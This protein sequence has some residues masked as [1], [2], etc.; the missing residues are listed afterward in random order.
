MGFAALLPRVAPGQSPKDASNGRMRVGM[1]LSFLRANNRE[2]VFADVFKQSKPWI[3]QIPGKSAPWDTKIPIETDDS[4]WPKLKPGQA[5]GT[6]MCVGMEGHYP[7]GEYVCAYAGKGSISFDREAKITAR[8]DHLITL[9]VTPGDRGM[10]LRIDESDPADPVREIRVTPAA[11]VAAKS[12][13]HPVFIERLRP[14]GCLRFMDWQMTN[15]TRL[16]EWSQRAK[17][18]DARQCEEI[19][20]VAPEYIIELCNELGADAWVC[21]PHLASDDFILNFARL[22]HERL[23]PERKVHVEWSNEAWNNPFKQS[24]WIR[25][26]AEKRG[27]HPA[28]ATADE[29]MKDWRI[30]SEVFASDP[31]RLVRVAAGWHMKSGYTARMLERLDGN[32]DAVACGCYFKPTKAQLAGFD[33]GTTIPQVLAACS[34]EWKEEGL[35]ALTEHKKLADDWSA[36]LGRRIPLL[37]YEGGQHL[38]GA[39][40][41]PPYEEAF[42]RAQVDPGMGQL[43]RTVLADAERVGVELFMPY[44]FVGQHGRFGAWGLLQYQDEPLA[45]S[46][47][48]AAVHE[49]AERVK[50]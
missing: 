10:H 37:V 48:F 2:W 8:G 20:G 18:S 31:K 24:K 17:P 13:F 1:N 40:K 11:L 50:P 41:A 28:Q 22:F 26:E 7:G 47:K 14:F 29:A 16:T 46:P 6:V 12:S 23:A 44:N 21:M 35:P 38:S 36:K 9:Q 4:G 34:T 33:A 30:W 15:K 45:Q 42:F 19:K 43:Y 25:G 27:L 49:F 5:A 39:G 3:S 32:F